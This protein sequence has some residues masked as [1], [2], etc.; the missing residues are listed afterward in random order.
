MLRRLLGVVVLV[1][2]L[3]L[4]W[5]GV[6]GTLAYGHAR[7]AAQEVGRVEQAV[8]AGDIDG[9]RQALQ[10]VQQETSAAHRLTSDPVWKV[11]AAF[12]FGGQNLRAFSA[13]AHAA[14]E[15]TGAGMPGLLDAA[16]GVNDFRA[17][18]GS[19]QLRPQ[20][21]Q[22]TVTGVA[23][24]DS[25]I[26]DARRE[27]RGIDRSYLLPQVRTGVDELDRSLDVAERLRTALAGQLP[28]G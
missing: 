6:R 16:E 27:L 7:Q 15:V 5:V 13:A 18:L 25:A 9:A 20:A 14:D 23:R 1:V 4:A 17:G 26:T 24:L 11:V 10:Q 12:P 21:L 2:V 22:E 19:G 8:G 3:A 28:P